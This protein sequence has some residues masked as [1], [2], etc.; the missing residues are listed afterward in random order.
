LFSENDIV[1]NDEI[2]K[3]GKKQR[4]QIAHKHVL[5]CNQAGKKQKSHFEEE[6]SSAGK[7]VSQITSEP[8]LLVASFHPV[9]PNEMGRHGKIGRAG[10]LE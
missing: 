9:S 7:V 3:S 4:N 10:A 6:Y 1:V 8:V 5:L 2:E